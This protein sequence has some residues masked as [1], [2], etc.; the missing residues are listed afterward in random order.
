MA[1]VTER[2][3]QRLRK[4]YLDGLRGLAFHLVRHGGGLVHVGTPTV[5]LPTETRAASAAYCRM[6]SLCLVRAWK[7]ATASDSCSVH[8]V[9]GTVRGRRVREWLVMMSD[10]RRPQEFLIPRGVD[11]V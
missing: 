5:R 7:R 11:R 3:E 10:Q 1:E 8:Y 2:A 6:G 4:P 9:A